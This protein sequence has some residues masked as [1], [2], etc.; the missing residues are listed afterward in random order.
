MSTAIAD[1][2]SYRKYAKSD[3]ILVEIISFV[4]KHKIG[5]CHLRENCYCSKL[6]PNFLKQQKQF[7]L[8]VYNNSLFDPKFEYN[9]T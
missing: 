3:G 9:A 5:I 1:S 4:L 8:D 7:N 6:Y 2:L